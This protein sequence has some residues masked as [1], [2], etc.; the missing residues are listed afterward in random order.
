MKFAPSDFNYAHRGLWNKSE[1]P[2][3][4]LWAFREAAAAGYGIEYDVRSSSDGVPLLFHDDKLSRM[5]SQTGQFED[6]TSDQLTSGGATLKDSKETIPALS[7]LLE[8]WPKTLPLLTELKID[9]RTDGPALANRCSQLLNAHGGLFTIMSFDEDTVRA[10]PSDDTAGQLLLPISQTS[11]AEFAAKLARS[12]AG[13]PNY[14][15]VWHEDAAAARS[16]L[17]GA[18]PLFIYTSRSKADHTGVKSAGSDIGVIFE[19][20]VPD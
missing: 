1:I 9:G 12:A 20:Y 8:F 13:R 17:A 14:A 6:F 10:V 18:M 11:P 2:E 19:H 5:T 15:C 4:S 3:N 7:D 16:R